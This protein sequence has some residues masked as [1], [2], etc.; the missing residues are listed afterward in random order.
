MLWRGEKN[1]KNAIISVWQLETSLSRHGNFVIF[2]GTK[3]DKKSHIYKS[4]AISI[5]QRTLYKV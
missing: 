3:R 2:R 1:A 4:S 5:K